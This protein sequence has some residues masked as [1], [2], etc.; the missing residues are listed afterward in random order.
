MK[1]FGLLFPTVKF[2]YK[3][4]FKILWEASK[5]FT[6]LGKIFCSTQVCIAVAASRVPLLYDKAE[7]R[8]YW[9]L[10]VTSINIVKEERYRCMMILFASSD[11]WYIF[12][13]NS[14]FMW[15]TEVFTCYTINHIRDIDHW[16]NWTSYLYVIL[17]DQTS[18]LANDTFYLFQA[19]WYVSNWM[20]V[21]HWNLIGNR[22]IWYINSRRYLIHYN[23][24]IKWFWEIKPSGRKVEV[25]KSSQIFLEMMSVKVN[26]WSRPHESI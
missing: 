7:T 10:E 24:G 11:R 13:V 15:C 23:M 21:L 19:I 14:V 3:Q 5:E 2:A 17:W 6:T 22:Y 16:S 1:I 12:W 20:K 8:C 18:L 26:F 25:A 9:L 4:P